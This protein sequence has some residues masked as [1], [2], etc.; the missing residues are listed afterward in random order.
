MSGYGSYNRGG[1]AGAG[2]SFGAYGGGGYGGAPAGG[3]FGPTAGAYGGS[4]AGYGG[5]GYGTGAAGFGVG[6]GTYANFT[7]ATVGY[8]GFGNVSAAGYGTGMTQGYAGGGGTGG[9]KSSNAGGGSGGGVS[10]DRQQRSVFVGNIPYK[11]TENELIQIFSQAGSVVAFRLV[12][13]RETGRPKGF[14]FCEYSDP[15]GA[16]TALEM[17]N[18][19]ELHGRSLRVGSSK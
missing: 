16:T 11:A 19:T 7:G 2:G 15:A 8:G 14:G 5:A 3:Q 6:N 10:A 18:G 1:F 17:L 13:D 4:F 9:Y 12:A